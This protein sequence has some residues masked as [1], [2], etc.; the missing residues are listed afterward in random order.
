MKPIIIVMLVM[1]PIKIVKLVMNQNNSYVSYETN[2][3]S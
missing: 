2:N 3:K 1:K